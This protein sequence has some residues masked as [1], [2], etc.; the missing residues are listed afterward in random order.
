M[1]KDMKIDD[2]HPRLRKPYTTGG[3]GGLVKA[4]DSRHPHISFVIPVSPPIAMVKQN[5][6]INLLSDA[7]T[8]LNRLPAFDEMDELDKLIN[9]LFVRRE[10][11]QSS[12][13]EGT[14]STI[15]A[16]L[17]PTILD[18]SHTENAVLSVRGYAHALEGI[19]DEAYKKK[20]SIFSLSTVCHLHTEFMKKDPG[21]LGLPGELRTPGK[22]GALVYIGGLGRPEDSI[23]NPVPPEH[24]EESLRKVLLWFSDQGLAATGDAGVGISLIARIAIGH[25][26]FEAVHPFPDGNG[27]VGRVLWPLQMI[28]SGLMPLY[29]SGYVEKEKQNYYEAL[30]FAQKKL[31]YSKII[32]FISSAIISSSYDMKMTKEKILAL[33]TL[34]QERGRFRKG[35]TAEKAL[36][37]ILKMPIFTTN[38]LR[39]AVGCSM[40]AAAQAVD[41]M[42]K[43]CIIRERTGFKRNR[44]FAAE[45]V[46]ALLAR[47][48]GSDVDLAMEK[49]MRILSPGAKTLFSS[50]V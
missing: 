26:H 40:P 44:I 42:L 10:A 41:D 30:Q 17:A 16:V 43:R 49:A 19:F 39:E 45:E 3:D 2:L 25:A 34:W 22:A 47:D 14:W 8:A 35:S 4:C 7:Q 20:E 27:R 9:Y 5:F 29:L 28:A 36:R 48:H 38:N 24:V 18:E 50:K 23:Y 6:S 11:V 13:L 46:I 1:L 33:P 21:Y 31:D 12:R 37:L 15:D 32:D